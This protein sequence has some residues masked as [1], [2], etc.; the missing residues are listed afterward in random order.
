MGARVVCFG[1]DDHGALALLAPIPDI[2]VHAACEVVGM[3]IEPA[4][5]RMGRM[6]RL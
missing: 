5:T 6:T 4:P 1:Q 3:A 2:K